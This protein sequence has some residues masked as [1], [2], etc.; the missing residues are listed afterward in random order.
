[1]KD[2]RKAAIKNKMGDGKAGIAASVNRLGQIPPRYRR[3]EVT[4]APPTHSK[5][6]TTELVWSVGAIEVF[7]RLKLPKG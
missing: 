4:T 7:M 2:G 6:R 1:M 3:E 5:R